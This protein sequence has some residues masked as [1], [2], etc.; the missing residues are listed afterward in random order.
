LTNSGICGTSPVCAHAG[1][2]AGIIDGNAEKEIAL[3]V[4]R[5]W[6]KPEDEIMRGSV[7]DTGERKGKGT[8]KDE[9]YFEGSKLVDLQKLLKGVNAYGGEPGGFVCDATHAAINV[10]FGDG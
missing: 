2:P 6:V 4:Q 5:S 9:K 1:G 8:R 3:W 7:D 10:P